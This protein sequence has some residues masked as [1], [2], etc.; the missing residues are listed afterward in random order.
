MPAVM[1][2]RRF[3]GPPDSGNG[4][5]SCG[6]VAALL[7]AP[8]VEVTLRAPPPLERELRDRPA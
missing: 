4:G 1:I 6:V 5:Y 7:D 2:P 3:N 8:A